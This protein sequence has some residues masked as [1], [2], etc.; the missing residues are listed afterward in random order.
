MDIRKVVLFVVAWFAFSNAAVAS[1]VV[2]CNSCYNFRVAA[3][4]SGLT[5]KVSVVD[6]N[7]DG[8]Q[9]FNVLYEYERQM[10]IALPIATNPK[11][12]AAFHNIVAL[13]ESGSAVIVL[14]ANRPGADGYP[15]PAAF[16]ESN[17]HDIV[18][19]AS[20]RG[21][22]GR[23]IASMYTGADTGNATWDSIALRIQSIGFSV[24][25]GKLGVGSVIVVIKWKDKSRTVYELTPQNLYEADYVKGESAD[26]D[27][28]PL[29]DPAA[30]D[31][32]TGGSF[33]GE[34]V[35]SQP[36]GLNNWVQTARQFGIPVTNTSSGKLRGR[37]DWDGRRLSCDMN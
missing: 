24:I 4:S 29:P 34:Y 13:S 21:M 23:E 5:G 36:Q 14:D 32:N 27:M 7:A 35:F 22:L 6:F 1:G 8:I 30:V 12:S 15:F 19:S 31:P 17:A 25:G 37:C 11:I 26:G 9:S 33:A 16:G 3:E 28:N 10:A 20:L 18:R 2:R